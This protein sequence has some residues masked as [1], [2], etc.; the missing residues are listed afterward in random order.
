MIVVYEEYAVKPVS[1]RPPMINHI[2]HF[3]FLQ[4]EKIHVIGTDHDCTTVKNTRNGTAGLVKES[5]FEV[6]S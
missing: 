6:K 5:N 1:C 2:Q 4:Q 3:V